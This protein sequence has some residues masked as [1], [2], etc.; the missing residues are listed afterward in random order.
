MALDQ[1]I[2][3]LTRTLAEPARGNQWA[4][5]VRTRLAAVHAELDASRAGRSRDGWLSARERS[6]NRER[7]RLSQRLAAIGPKILDHPETETALRELRRVAVD[8]EHYRQRLHDLMYDAVA[9]ELGGS[10]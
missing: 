6:S 5:S 7:L 9:L 2:L 3:D 8:L 10:E 4:A 1:A